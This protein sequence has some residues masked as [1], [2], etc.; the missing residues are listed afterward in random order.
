MEKKMR[1]RIGNVIVLMAVSLVYSTMPR[2]Q[3]TASKGDTQ[4][5]SATQAANWL[6]HGAWRNGLPL[7][8]HPS[9]DAE[10]FFAQYRANPAL[11]DKVFTWL[12]KT[13][14]DSIPAGKYPIDG[15][16]AF[17]IISE[18]STNPLDQ[19]KWESHR[20]YIDLHSVIRGQ[21]RIG[22]AAFGKATVTEPYVPSTDIAHYDASGTIYTV[23]PGTFLLFL[24]DNVHR[25]G[26]RAEGAP[27]DK[28]LVIKIRFARPVAMLDYY[29]N[30][31]WHRDAKGDSVRYHYTWTDSANS[32]FSKL[33][34]LFLETG[35]ALDSLL[36]APTLDNLRTA[37]VYVIVDPDTELESPKPNYVS[38]KDV[39]ALREW[40]KAGGV[41]VLMGNDKGNAEF[42]HFNQLAKE[43]GMHFN[44]DCKNHCVS[45]D[46]T[47]GEIQIP[48]GHTIFRV[49][50]LLFMKDVSSLSLVAP[51]RPC[52]VKN[53]DVLAA[54]ARFGKGMVFAVGDPWIYNEYIDNHNLEPRFQNYQGAEAWVSWL[55]GQVEVK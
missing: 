38:S 5:S 48:S 6:R 8:P 32:G 51:A 3:M 10:A 4:T 23:S 42:A 15:D 2:A 11:W 47:A 36:V 50:L 16:N 25:A 37:S 55:K 40:V 54:T 39:A 28:K 12:K 21:E 19:T 22:E 53:G 52:I 13:N 24:P 30:N 41:L 35:F 14:L 27:T 18:G 43:F 45:N 34:G 7:K 44:E 9:V 33:G 17:A 49:P 1:K 46:H 20:T 29:F 31:E 26:I